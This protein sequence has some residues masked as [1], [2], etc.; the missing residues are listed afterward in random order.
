MDVNY[1]PELHYIFYDTFDCEYVKERDINAPPERY[2]VFFR[3]VKND[4]FV[5][6]WYV[7]DGKVISFAYST[8]DKTMEVVPQ[9]RKNVE[10]KH[11]VKLQR[12]RSMTIPPN[13]FDR[14]VEYL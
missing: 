5:E 4:L 3:G 8:A 11:D 9:L 1:E 10:N 13:D 14:V 12:I 6:S 2:I 7:T